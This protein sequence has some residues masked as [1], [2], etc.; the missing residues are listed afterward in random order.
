[1]SNNYSVTFEKRGGYI[2]D[3]NTIVDL[4]KITNAFVGKEPDVTVKL[5]GEHTI[6]SSD[7]EKVLEDIYVKSNRIVSLDISARNHRIEPSR[8]ISIKLK[9]KE[10]FEP[11]IAVK[12]DGDR[13]A[14][15][16]VRLEIESVI[17]G[18]AE[19][20]S[21]FFI[22]FNFLT[23]IGYFPVV[24]ALVVLFVG[25][26]HT[27]LLGNPITEN[28]IQISVILEALIVLVL[29]FPLKNKMFP[30]I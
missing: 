30:G 1:M 4:W 26:L 13:E 22:P 23:A 18:R 15:T 2:F 28:K 3:Q 29:F 25:G 19:W 21:R 6:E 9:T 8:S 20:Y 7:V 5:A 10:A 14:S 24:I 16:V 12:I 27:L 11:V 17:D